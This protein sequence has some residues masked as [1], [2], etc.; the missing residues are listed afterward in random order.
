MDCSHRSRTWKGKGL[1]TCLAIPGPNYRIGFSRDDGL[2]IRT[3]LKEMYFS[4]VTFQFEEFAA[5]VQVANHRALLVGC[6]GG[7]PLAIG[8]PGDSTFTG[9]KAIPGT[10]E[11]LAFEQSAELTLARC[12]INRNGGTA[13]GSEPFPIWTPRQLTDGAGGSLL[14]KNLLRLADL[15]DSDSLSSTRVYIENTSDELVI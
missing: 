1:P 5:A 14:G 10:S 8:A 9:D 4:A 11:C 3:P 13:C 6:D 7:K 2:A 15:P 12:I